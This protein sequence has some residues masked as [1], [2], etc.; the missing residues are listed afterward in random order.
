MEIKVRNYTCF[1]PECHGSIKGSDLEPKPHGW[2]AVCW[3]C[4]SD[5]YTLPRY[6]APDDAVKEMPGVPRQTNTFA[7]NLTSW[8]QA[9]AG[10]IVNQPPVGQR[11]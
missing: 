8:Q 11:D 4:D 7:P 5:Q 10:L 9:F 2:G 1:S 3:C 6:G